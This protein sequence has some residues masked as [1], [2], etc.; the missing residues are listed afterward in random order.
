MAPQFVT[1]EG[2]DGAGK[3]T[4]IERLAAS[5]TAAGKQ[6]CV[7]REPGG[8][9]LGERVREVFLHQAM[10]LDAETLLV[11]AARAEHLQT[12][13][14]PALAQGQWVLC[15]RFSDSTFAYQGG[16]KAHG[17]PAVL[18]RLHALDRWANPHGTWP[19][20]TFLFDLDPAL[21]HQRRR[22]SRGHSDRFEA[23]SAAF[24]ER[25]RQ[26]YLRTAA[27]EPGRFCVLDANLTVD[28]LAQQ[29]Q[30]AMD[31]LLR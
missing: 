24:F 28:H 7:T 30:D 11:Y 15:D 8:T 22:A 9:P 3:S 18:T 5:L 25:V 26:H 1:F 20:R 31:S 10:G 19:C 6:V 27:T 13:I 16:G 12:V 23:Q 4:Q 17:D 2:I 29:I 21:A 14:E